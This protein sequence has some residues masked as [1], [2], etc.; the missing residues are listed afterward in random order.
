[1]IPGGWDREEDTTNIAKGSG[2]PE[3]ERVPKGGEA[4]VH[5]SLSEL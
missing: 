3:G 1:M 2:Q 4:F 5:K